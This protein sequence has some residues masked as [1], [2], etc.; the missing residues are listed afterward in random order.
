MAYFM[1]VSIQ[2]DDKIAIFEM[3]PKSGKLQAE[4]SVACDRAA[5]MA[6]DRE[7]KYPEEF[8]QELTRLGWLSILIPEE[9]Y[10][11]RSAK[12]NGSHYG[13]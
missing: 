11:C 4:G 9:W 13:S 3:D 12:M 5:P 1:Y 6:V 2:N 10:Y 7:K 8:V